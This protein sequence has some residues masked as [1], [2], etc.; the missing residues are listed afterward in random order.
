[1][2]L[3]ATHPAVPELFKLAKEKLELPSYY[4]LAKSLGVSPSRIGNYT[5][6]RATPDEEMCVK[7]AKIL[8]WPEAYLLALVQMER[9]HQGKAR[10]ILRENLGEIYQMCKT[11]GGATVGALVFAAALPYLLPVIQDY[12]QAGATSQAMYIMSNSGPAGGTLAALA[13]AIL[14]AALA[15]ILLAPETATRE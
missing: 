9:A 13:L 7:L 1:M 5:S 3:P 12:D 14:A 11:F 6:G 4:A 10:A 8:D 15:R 2:R